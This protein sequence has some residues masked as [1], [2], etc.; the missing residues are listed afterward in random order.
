MSTTECQ[1]VM[2]SLESDAD[3]Q[4]LNHSRQRASLPCTEFALNSHG[5]SEL[6]LP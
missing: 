4:R 3:T 1:L 5:D 6:L 2:T